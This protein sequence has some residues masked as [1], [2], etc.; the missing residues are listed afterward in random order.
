[1]TNGLYARNLVQLYNYNLQARKVKTVKTLTWIAKSTVGKTVGGIR[2]ASQA[3]PNN[4]VAT[5]WVTF[6]SACI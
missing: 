5:D 1:M 2:D 4:P 6:R 3:L